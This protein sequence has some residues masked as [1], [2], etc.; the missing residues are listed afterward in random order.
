MPRLR[1]RV[2]LAACLIVPS[3]APA[4]LPRPAASTTIYV[5]GGITAGSC[6]SYAPDTRLC[7]GGRDAAFKT[8]A[9]G[10][11]RAEAGRRLLI[12]AGVYWDPRVPAASGA[13]DRPI[14][15]RNAER[16][17]VTL[18]HIDAP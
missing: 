7:S 14:V 11:A 10:A 2:R 5:D 9:G 8:L 6:T 1:V 13:A 4:A 16:E 18:S 15:F 12:R 17:T 3:P